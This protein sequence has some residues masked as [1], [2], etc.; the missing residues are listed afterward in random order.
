[1]ADGEAKGE[2]ETL[3]GIDQKIVNQKDPSQKVTEVMLSEMTEGN[4]DA[5]DADKKGTLKGLHGREHLYV[6]RGRSRKCK[7]ETG[8]KANNVQSNPKKTNPRNYRGRSRE[9]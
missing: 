8:S 7:Y 2:D 4:R 9:S 3:I 5:L 1:M 6:P